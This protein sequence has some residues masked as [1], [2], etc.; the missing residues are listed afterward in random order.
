MELITVKIKNEWIGNWNEYE[1][2][3]SAEW[4]REKRA[5][6]SAYLKT[7]PSTDL[8]DQESNGECRAVIDLSQFKGSDLMMVNAAITTTAKNIRIPK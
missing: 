8:P 1:L 2:P 4:L 7:R 3:C 5:E 6:W